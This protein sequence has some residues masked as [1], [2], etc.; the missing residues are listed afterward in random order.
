MTQRW[1]MATYEYY[2]K[3]C[4]T[5][6]DVAHPITD[7]PTIICVECSKPRVKKFG[8]GAV[9]FKGSGWGKDR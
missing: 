2:C 3:Q 6:I 1:M 8:V 4:D 9:T 5:S 7:T